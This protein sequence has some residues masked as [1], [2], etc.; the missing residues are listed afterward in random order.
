VDRRL[1]SPDVERA[2]RQADADGAIRRLPDGYQT[3]LGKFF[4]DG[5]ELCTSEWQKVAITRV[6]FRNAR[7]VAPGHTA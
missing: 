2:A 4:S 7:P 3:T 1:E 5:Q 6:F